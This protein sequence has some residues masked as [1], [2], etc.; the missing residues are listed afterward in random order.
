MELNQ[1]PNLQ[2]ANQGW[3]KIIPK[4]FKSVDQMESHIKQT[5]RIRKRNHNNH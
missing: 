2:F 4:K 3:G 1:I 5:A